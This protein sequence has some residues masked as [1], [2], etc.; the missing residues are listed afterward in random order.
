MGELF[1]RICAVSTLRQ[2]WDRV[3][4]KNSQGGLDDK[5]P[6]ELAGRSSR[7]IEKLAEDLAAQR[8]TPIPY[9]AGAI[10]KFNA[11]NEWRKL[12]MPAV[13]DKVAQQAV[14]DVIGPIFEKKFSDCS[15]AY[16]AA[17]GPVKAIKRVEHII[18]TK[19]N[20]QWTATP[21]IDRFFDTLDH[22]I[23]MARLQDVIKE[24]EIINLASLWLHAGIIGSAGT[25]E[26][27]QEGIAQGSVVSP[28]F[29]NIYLDSLDKVAVA[30]NISYVRYSDN[31]IILEE[32]REKLLAAFKCLNDH[33]EG[34]LK[35]KLNKDSEICRTLDQGFVF[36]GVFFRGELRR[37][38]NGKVAKVKRQLNWLFNAYG[39]KN[40]RRTIEKVNRSVTGTRRYYSFLDPKEQFAEFDGY[41]T[42]KLA[43][44]CGELLRRGMIKGKDGVKDLIAKVEFYSSLSSEEL[45]GKRRRTAETIWAGRQGGTGTREEKKAP[46]DDQLPTAARLDAPA[47]GQTQAGETV[48]EADGPAPG[49]EGAAHGEAPGE[50][51]KGKDLPPWEDNRSG[52]AVSFR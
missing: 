38:G 5:T 50:E 3:L 14:V 15:Y 6:R 48:E 26:D 34:S 51:A 32:S 22:S 21:D 18:R 42:G 31:F 13:V 16:R 11:K 24:P 41:L 40:Y 39:L 52:K 8:Y 36:L 49:M 4:S 9:A 17:K 19:G 23:L 29:S 47:A 45:Q 43:G 12:S 30:R 33:L 35:L 10:P 37:I 44:F 2:A 28:L 7:I 46:G 27:P 20:V 25:W 1:N